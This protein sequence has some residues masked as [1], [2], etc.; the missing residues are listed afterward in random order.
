MARTLQGDG[1]PRG[2][3]ILA[4]SLGVSDSEAGPESG[5]GYLEAPDGTICHIEWR[6]R[7]AIHF[8]DVPI[9]E[10]AEEFTA[11]SNAEADY[12]HSLFAEDWRKSEQWRAVAPEFLE[13]LLPN[14]EPQWEKWRAAN[15]S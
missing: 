10:A 11:L 8:E 3:R 9:V 14:L 6:T 1:G 7:D 15:E 4:F 2:F 13:Q 12:L 5:E